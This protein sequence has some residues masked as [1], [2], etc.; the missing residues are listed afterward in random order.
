MSGKIFVL[1]GGGLVAMTEQRYD[2]EIDL[3]NLIEDYPD[4]LAGDQI[5]STSPRKWLFV[6]REKDVPDA[7]DGNGRWALDHLFL[8]Q[9]GVPTLVEVKR[10][11]DTRIRREVVGQ[12]LDYAAHGVAYWSVTTLRDDFAKTWKGEADQKLAELLGIDATDEDADE[13][14]VEV[15]P[16]VEEFW[17]KV[18]TNLQVGRLRLLFV[19]DEFPKEILRVIEFLND[20]MHSIDVLAVEIKQFVSQKDTEPQIKTLVPRVIGQTEKKAAQRDASVAGG[21]SRQWDET[22]FCEEVQSRCGIAAADVARKIIDWT[23]RRGLN[24]IWNSAIKIGS[25]TPTLTHKGTEHPLLMIDSFGRFET[26]FA[27]LKKSRPFE[28]DSK[29]EELRRRLNAIPNV[30][31]PEDAIDKRYMRKLALFESAASTD[32]LLYT[33]DWVIEEIKAVC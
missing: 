17:Q 19:A 13:I 33:M 12:M 18:S 14:E 25:S 32:A 31:L 5:N 3:Q 20:S 28:Q 9:D 16:A 7:Q 2:R 22:T 24:P 29:R 6:K 21:E 27:P 8:D 15:N 11:T 23:N 1:Q 10:S 30:D 26:Y 4:L